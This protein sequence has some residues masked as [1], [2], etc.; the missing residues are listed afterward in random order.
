VVAEEEVNPTGVRL[1]MPPE[2]VSLVFDASG[3]VAKMV[4]GGVVMDRSIG[5]TR[6]LGGVLRSWL[7]HECLSIVCRV[8]E[9]VPVSVRGGGR[10]GRGGRR[11]RIGWG[12]SLLSSTNPLCSGQ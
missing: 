1:E 9:S 3:K 12:G 4:G 5:N 7:L 6:G 8:C 10:G 2:S 11:G